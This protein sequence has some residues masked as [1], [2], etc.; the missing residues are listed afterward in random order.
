MAGSKRSAE[1]LGRVG[2]GIP[3][4]DVGAAEVVGLEASAPDARVSDV[5]E[6]DR[7]SFASLAASFSAFFFAFTFSFV[8]LYA[9]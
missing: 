7:P 2:S 4:D 8:S 3:V 6:R 5:R 1:R 9:E